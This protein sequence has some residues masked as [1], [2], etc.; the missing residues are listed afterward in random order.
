MLSPV[1][2]AGMVVGAS[3]IPGANVLVLGLGVFVLVY[4]SRRMPTWWAAVLFAGSFA[5][6][7]WTLQVW[8]VGRR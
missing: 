6:S 7:Y 5:V 4:M 1:T 8:G 2:A 3:V